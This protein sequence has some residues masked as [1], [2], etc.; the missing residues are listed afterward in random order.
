M[1][2]T[3]VVAHLWGGGGER[4]MATL[5]N[6]WARRGEDVTVLSFVG[7]EAPAYE[8]D[9]RLQVQRLGLLR[10]SSNPLGGFVS[11]V[12]RIRVLRR[13]IRDAKPDIVVSFMETTNVLTLLATRGLRLPIVI[14]EQTDPALYRV[15]RRWAA[16]R[17]LTYRF[18]DVLVCPVRASLVR[19]QSSIRVRGCVIPNP[20]DVPPSVGQSR[21][22]SHVSS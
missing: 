8:I 18:A 6:G 15:P 7:E 3:L 19:F 2:I 16:L 4:A 20:V 17:R 22:Q 9:P 5:A 1:R 14:C 21:R 12:R 11:N 13:A 10:E